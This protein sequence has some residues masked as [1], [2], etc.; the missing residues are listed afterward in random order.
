M[1]AVSISWYS[2]ADRLL[3]SLIPDLLTEGFQLNKAVKLTWF[4]IFLRRTLCSLGW[5]KV[6]NFYWNRD[7][8]P[9]FQ[10]LNACL[11]PKRKHWFWQLYHCRD[12]VSI[13]AKIIWSCASLYLIS[14]YFH[15][16]RDFLF[17]LYYLFISLAL[18]SLYIY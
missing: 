17:C 15:L 10:D 6:A 14:L 9:S 8:N 11:A 12:V 7:A 2:W 18:I 3:L 13:L 4:F 1:V 5:V 16:Y